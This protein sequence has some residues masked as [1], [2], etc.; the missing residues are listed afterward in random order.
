MKTCSACNLDVNNEDYIECSKCDGVYHLLCLNMQQG[1]TPDATTKWLC[2]LCMSKQPKVDNSAHPARPSTPTAQAEISFNVTR[3]KA[4]GKSELSVPTNKDDYI[5]RSELRE[6]LREEMLNLMKTNNAELRS[7]LSTFSERITNLNTSIEFMSD[8]FDKMTEGLQ[9]QQQEIITLKK[10]NACLRTEVN[11]LSGKLQQLDQLSRASTLEIQCVPDK[12][13]ENVLQ[14]VKQ[15]G[16]TVNCTINDQDI[17]Y[18]SRIAKINPNS[19]RPRS[20]IAKLSSPRLRDTVLSAVSRYNKENP[21]NKLSTADFGF[22]PENKTPVF[23]LESLSYEN[24]QLHAAARQRGK[25]L[26]FKFVWVRA[27][28]IYMRKNETSEAIFIRN[29]SAL[30][31]IQ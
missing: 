2:P 24:K 9:Q 1:L 5:R 19:T 18:C 13:T 4:P 11:S 17:H 23:V 30:D 27:G 7:T 20:I 3:R 25:E 10:E 12:K 14:I 21:Q 26:N 22:N 28:R 8:K 29:A 15:L 16:R 31:K 6:L